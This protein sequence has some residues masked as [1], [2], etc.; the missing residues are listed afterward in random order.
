M[1]YNITIF[2]LRSLPDKLEITN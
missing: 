1:K 2:L